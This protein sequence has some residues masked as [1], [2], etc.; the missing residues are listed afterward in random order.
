MSNYLIQDSTLEAIGDAIREKEGSSSSILVTDMPTRIIDANQ[1]P[2]NPSDP[3]QF[4][5]YILDENGSGA[6]N[7]AQFVPSYQQKNVT[8]TGLEMVVTADQGYDALSQVTV[9]GDTNLIASNIKKDVT[10]Y[11][12]TGT[13]E[14]GSP[15]PAETLL[16]SYSGSSYAGGDTGL[17]IEQCKQYSKI[18]IDYAPAPSKET[19]HSFLSSYF[20]N[21]AKVG[22]IE[23]TTYEVTDQYNMYL[24]SISPI[25]NSST[26]GTPSELIYIARG[27]FFSSTN[28]KLYFAKSCT[29]KLANG[30][31]V[32]TDQSSIVPRAIYGIS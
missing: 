19:T 15:A 4:T 30:T 16:W 5:A 17:T 14:G 6:F 10:V 18:R 22:Y 29:T 27:L 21:A 7:L 25:F 13:Y 2:V 1:I 31:I 9:A 28:R 8:P 32:N 23:R 3:T 26:G 20:I 24:T 11:G 12:V